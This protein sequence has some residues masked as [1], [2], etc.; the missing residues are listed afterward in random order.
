MG[1]LYPGRE[2]AA[3]RGYGIGVGAGRVDTLGSPL[4]RILNKNWIERVILQLITTAIELA[5]NPF[6]LVGYILLGVYSQ[7]LWQSLKYGFLWGVAI[8]IFKIALSG[9]PLADMNALMVRFGLHL[10]GAVIITVVV[11]YL[12]RMLRRGSGGGS[13]GGGGKGRSNGAD[14]RPPHLRR[15]K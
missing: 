6:A 4:H 11:F 14:K 7:R 10:L 9:S 5:A 15:V 8:F 13:R 2:A 1:R 3:S 12:Y